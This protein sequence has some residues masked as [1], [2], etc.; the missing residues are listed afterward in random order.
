MNLTTVN[1]VVTMSSLEL[2]DFINAYEGRNDL[3]H[4]NFMAKVP[5]VLGEG[6]VIQFK[7]TYVHPQNGQVYPCYNFP[8][9]EACLMAMSYSYEL[10][11]KVYD[12]MTALEEQRNVASLPDFT[13]PVIAARAWADAEEGRL[14]AEKNLE[15]A[16]PAIG[17]YDAV[18]DSTSLTSVGDA[19]KSLGFGRNHFFK[20]LR[21]K[22]FLMKDYNTPYQKWIEARYFQVKYQ[23]YVDE[24]G[25]VKHRPVT[26]IT[27]KGLQYLQK[28]LD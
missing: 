27:G 28:Q 15:E 22:E 4:A 10:Q 3:T 18:G 8:K 14:I 11:A 1:N 24:F 7:D 6:G 12:R 23:S 2:V 5:K 19:A 13:N 9:R 25:E 17:F 20:W 16:Q 26:F 21:N